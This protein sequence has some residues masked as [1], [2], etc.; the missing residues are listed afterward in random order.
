MN[1]PSA[2]IA[3]ERRRPTRWKPVPAASGP[4]VLNVGPKTLNAL[5]VAI[6][7]EVDMSPEEIAAAENQASLH[8][9]CCTV[10]E[11]VF[12]SPRAQQEVVGMLG[13]KAKQAIEDAYARYVR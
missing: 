6:K 9:A 7:K 8:Q 2:V 4:S 5:A 13:S 1:C 12:G 11:A 3:S 10:R